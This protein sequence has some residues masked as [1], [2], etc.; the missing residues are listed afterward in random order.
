M[1]LVDSSIWID[2]LRC[3]N[4]E[5]ALALAEGRVVQHGFVTAELALGS[6]ANRD[7][8]IAMLDLLP[9]APTI[10]HSSLLA[11][12]TE[13]RLFGTG[14][15]MVDAHLL[16]SAARLQ[17][18]TVWTSDRRLAEQGERLGLFYRS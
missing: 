15:G 6:L 17:N 5:L 12:I 4:A 2:H 9:S 3:A 13:H 16:A 18:A 14:L 1:I 11:F 8:F 7:R 10:D